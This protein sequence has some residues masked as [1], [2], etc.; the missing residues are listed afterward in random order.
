MELIRQT[1]HIED[2]LSRMQVKLATPLTDS[3]EGG[4]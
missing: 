3:Y 2:N 1:M 4:D